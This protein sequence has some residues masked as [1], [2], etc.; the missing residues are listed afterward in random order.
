MKVPLALVTECSPWALLAAFCN[1]RQGRHR[2]AKW[3]AQHLS[4]E[5]LLLTPL[6]LLSANEVEDFFFR[7]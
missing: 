7:L 6:Y 5:P 3:I 1:I 2:Q 4:P